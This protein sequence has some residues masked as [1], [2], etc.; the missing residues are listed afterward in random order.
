[1]QRFYSYGRKRRK[2]KD[3][4][5]VLLPGAATQM[6]AKRLMKTRTRKYIEWLI[7][8]FSATNQEKILVCGNNYIFMN[9]AEKTS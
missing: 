9:K 5:D 3:V 8:L 1:M 7:M 6:D 2:V 4:S